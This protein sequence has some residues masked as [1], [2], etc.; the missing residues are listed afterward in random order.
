M[1]HAATREKAFMVKV[2]NSKLN[3]GGLCRIFKAGKKAGVAGRELK[4]KSPQHS[5]GIKNI[6][7][8]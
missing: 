3:S 8:G 1:S 2:N 6:R 7:L 4:G 5:G